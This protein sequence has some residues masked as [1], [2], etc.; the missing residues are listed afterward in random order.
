MSDFTAKLRPEETAQRLL[1]GGTSLS[2]ERGYF[3]GED[4]PQG[5]KE[6]RAIVVSGM[7]LAVAKGPGMVRRIPEPERSSPAVMCYR[8]RQRNKHTPTLLHERL[9]NV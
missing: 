7:L 4:Y 3:A 8:I 6:A 1:E 5:G 2:T 9:P